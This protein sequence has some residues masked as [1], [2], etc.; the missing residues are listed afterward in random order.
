MGKSCP[1]YFDGETRRTALAARRLA[2]RSLRATTMNELD[3]AA[4]ALMREAPAA[5]ARLALGRRARIRSASAEDVELPALARRVDK[6]LRVQLEGVRQP[7]RV[8]I[9]VAASWASNVPRRVFGYRALLWREG[10]RLDSVVLCLKPGERQG[11]PL[12]RHEERG[13]VTRQV[14][15]FPVVCLWKLRERDLRGLGPAF[16][17][18]VPYVRDAAPDLVERTMQEL[19]RLRPVERR[20]DLQG[21]LA[22][23]AGNVYPRIDWLGRIPPEVVVENTFIKAVKQLGAREERRRSVTSALRTRLGPAAARPFIRRLADCSPRTLGKL[24]KLIE[25]PATG[26]KLTRALEELLPER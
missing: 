26:A 1:A 6:L 10:A 13:H 5:F 12:G 9:E 2:R 4:K 11:E 19:S 23:F 22:V 16:L 15:T 17:P 8:H 21:A 18:F 20:A 24:Q 25:T 3:L 14:L 7:V